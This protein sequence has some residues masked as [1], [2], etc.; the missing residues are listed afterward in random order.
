MEQKGMGASIQLKDL[1]PLQAQRERI[2]FNLRAVNE[3][4]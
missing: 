4:S 3:R 2:T 1:L